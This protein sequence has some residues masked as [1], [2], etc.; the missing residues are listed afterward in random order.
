MADPLPLYL[1][2]DGVYKA[3]HLAQPWADVISEGIILGVAAGLT[4]LAVGP[5]TPAAMG[6]SVAPGACWITNDGASLTEKYFRGGAWR[7][8]KETAVQ[9][10][11][12]ASEAN[13]RIDRVIAEVLDSQF[14]GGSDLG[15]L[16]VVKGTAAASPAAPAEPANALTLALVTVPAS[17]STIVVGNITDARPVAFLGGRATGTSTGFEGNRTAGTS[18]A[19]ASNYTIPYATQ[20]WARG[21]HYDAGLF[22]GAWI[23]DVPG[24]YLMTAQASW[25]S[26]AAGGRLCYLQKNG[27]PTVYGTRLHGSASLTSRVQAQGLFVGVIAGDG[28]N[29]QGRQDSGGALA[30]TTDG[31][32]VMNAVKLL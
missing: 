14:S 17:A 21:W 25:V 8:Q 29:A 22:G 7:L 18:R 10:G 27:T 23:C 4:P 12:E 16:R 15:R 32:N 20:I 26:G 5:A 11:I 28:F 24:T 9:L 2:V 6:V 13:P 30:E 19:D 31:T 1:N 3:E